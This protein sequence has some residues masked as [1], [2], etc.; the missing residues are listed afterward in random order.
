MQ[1]KAQEACKGCRR[2][3]ELSVNGEGGPPKQP[4]TE[5]VFG[6]S[7]CGFTWEMQFEP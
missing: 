1:N 2:W 5:Q 3:V 4:A 7:F 6:A